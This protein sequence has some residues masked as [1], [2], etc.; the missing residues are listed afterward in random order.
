M[1]TYHI[2]VLN[3]VAPVF[4]GS[5]QNYEGV[6]EAHPIFSSFKIVAMNTV[7]RSEL[8][9][10]TKQVLLPEQP[11]LKNIYVSAL[12]DYDR[13]Y[14]SMLALNDDCLV[15]DMDTHWFIEASIGIRN[16]LAKELYEIHWPV[17]NN[18]ALCLLNKSDYF[19]C[20]GGIPDHD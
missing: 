10:K 1:Q 18:S 11:S 5:I 13:E 2:Y 15:P 20:Y 14:F 3:A 7:W 6:I 8:V 12:Y 9:D 4:I 17:A 19:K 16:R